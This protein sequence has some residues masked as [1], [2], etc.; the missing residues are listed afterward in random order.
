MSRPTAKDVFTALLTACLLGAFL[1]ATAASAAPASGTNAG[2][3]DER[4]QF[5]EEFNKLRRIDAKDEMGNLLVRNLDEAAIWVVEVGEDIAEAPSAELYELMSAL[6]EGWKRGVKTPFVE[7]MEEYY[8]LLDSVAKRERRRL[9]SM[10]DKALRTQAKALEESDQAQLGVLAHEWEVI[11]KGFEKA[12]DKYYAS[13]AWANFGY[14]ND[15][16]AREDQADLRKAT[17]GSANCV[18]LREEIGLKDSIWSRHSERHRR[19]VGLGY[20]EGGEAGE[21]EAGEAEGE[22]TPD[23]SGPAGNASAASAALDFVLAGDMAEFERPCY[24]L[25]ELHALWNLIGLEGN[26]SS[27]IIDRLDPSA[28]VLREGANDVKV[29]V[30]R[31]GAADVDVPL[32]GNFEPV[33]FEIGDGDSKRTW[34]F[35]AKVGGQQDDYQG[36]RCDLS[37]QGN[38]MSVY[39]GPAGSV[40]GA[41]QETPIRIFDDNLDGIYGSLPTSYGHLGCTEGNYAPEMDSILIGTGT[42]ALPWSEIQKIGDAWYE[43]E[44]ANGGTQ[45]TATPKEVKTGFLKLKYKG[46]KPTWLVVKGASKLENAY[47]DLVA[48][49][50]KGLEVPVGRYSLFYGELRKGKKAQTIKTLILPGENTPTWKVESGKATEVELGAPYGFDFS[51]EQSGDRAIVKGSSVV[52][53]GVANERYERP[54]GCV[55]RPE[56]S[57]RVEGSKKGSKGERMYVLQSQVEITEFGWAAAWSPRDLTLE[58]GTEEPVELQLF[59]KKNKLFGKV[60]SDWK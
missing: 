28:I 3:Q 36:F 25:D 44:V 42:R 19:L 45:I 33:Q 48:G 24:T 29:D 55:P 7:R 40:A 56:V 20:G 43:L 10:R 32:T 60:E 27:K 9:K 22:A 53:T 58:L 59:E 17:M 38:F 47:F 51:F 14:L 49:S 57:F 18:K 8:S 52:V 46:G 4:A 54:W 35:L 1:P 5:R 50:G 41:I 34:A 26:G 31:D 13:E 12:W 23:P 16:D 15:E 2:S 11:A 39:Y 21:G 37:P 30:D 6:R